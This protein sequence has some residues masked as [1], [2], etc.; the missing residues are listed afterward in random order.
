MCDLCVH[1]WYHTHKMFTS[2]H[3]LFPYLDPIC[4]PF[5]PS[6]PSS[7]ALLHMQGVTIPSQRR[8]VQYYGHLIR[9][10]LLYTPKALYL[11]GMRLEGIPRVS[12]GTYSKLS[13][14]AYSMTEYT[15]AVT[16]ECMQCCKNYLYLYVVRSLFL[17]SALPFSF[18][19]F[20][21]CMVVQG[22]DVCLKDLRPHQKNRHCGRTSV[23]HT[24]PHLW[25]HQ[26]SILP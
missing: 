24:C 7:P 9:N 21:Y 11:K 16:H 18:S 1:I 22:K 13:L 25:R 15:N 4:T 17:L 12:S 8:Y 26:G 5:P 2:H 19:T 3:S 20:L 23:A 14:C 6:L 10:S